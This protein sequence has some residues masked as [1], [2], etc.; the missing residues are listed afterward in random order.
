MTLENFA[1]CLLTFVPLFLY[2]CCYGAILVCLHRLACEYDQ[3]CEKD[4]VKKPTPPTKAFYSSLPSSPRLVCI[5]SQ[6]LKQPNINM[7]PCPFS[8][9]FSTTS[10]LAS[11]LPPSERV[12]P[13]VSDPEASLMRVFGLDSRRHAHAPTQNT[14]THTQ[15][16][17]C[18]HR[19]TERWCSHTH[20]PSR[21]LDDESF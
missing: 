3:A 15:T 5:H 1:L 16:D 14:H 13:C 8:P 12:P 19:R 21:T 18:T 17:T 4:T 10:T 9:T 6:P 11:P 20:T 2:I 7:N